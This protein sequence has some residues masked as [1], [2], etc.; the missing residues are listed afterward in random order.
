MLEHLFAEHHVEL[1]GWITLAE[2][3]RREVEHRV[4]RPTAPAMQVS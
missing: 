3:E 4:A 2:I 1:V